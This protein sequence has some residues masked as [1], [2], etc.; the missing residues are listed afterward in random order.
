MAM[1][2]APDG[3]GPRTGDGGVGGDVDGGGMD[4]HSLFLYLLHSAAGS[5]KAFKFYILEE[6]QLMLPRSAPVA[7]YPHVEYLEVLKLRYRGNRT[8]T[9]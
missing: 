5:R 8:S 2:A 3:K 7:C 1:E 9:C 4:L 6:A